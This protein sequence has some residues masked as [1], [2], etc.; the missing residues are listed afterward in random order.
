MKSF[1]I[2]DILG[3]D[4]KME[5]IETECVECYTQSDK[6]GKVASYI[7]CRMF[8]FCYLLWQK[9]PH[10]YLYM[11]IFPVMKQVSYR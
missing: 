4:S 3:E 8:P 7:I 6:N 1:F 9:T 10:T 2:A 5:K 11:A